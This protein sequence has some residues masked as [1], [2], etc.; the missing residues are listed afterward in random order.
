M[1]LIA[2]L[3]TLPV[4]GP[5]AGA[6]WVARQIHKAAEAEL[7]DPVAIRRT[8]RDLEAQLEAGEIDEAAFEEAELVLLERLRSAAP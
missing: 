3:L 4:A 8:L 7:T 2:K 6:L 1:G 5:G